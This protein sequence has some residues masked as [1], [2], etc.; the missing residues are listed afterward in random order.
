MLAI[1]KR[2]GVWRRVGMDGEIS[3][4]DISE[5]IASLPADCDAELS[6]RLLIEAEAGYMAG[7]AERKQR[8]KGTDADR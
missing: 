2:Y 4:I 5:A 3:G 7:H 1:L 8:D 6:R